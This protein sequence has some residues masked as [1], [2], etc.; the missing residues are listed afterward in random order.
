[1]WMSEIIIEL[2]SCIFFLHLYIYFGARVRRCAYGR[3]KNG[4]QSKCLLLLTSVT[5][6]LENVLI[7]YDPILRLEYVLFLCRCLSLCSPSVSA[8]SCHF[9]SHDF[10]FRLLI[11]WVF[12]RLFGVVIVDRSNMLLIWNLSLLSNW[13]STMTR[14]DLI[15]CDCECHLWI[16]FEKWV[17]DVR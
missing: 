13:L 2:F 9:F 10:P 14:F 12:F 6:E 7:Y 3:K 17:R 16:V 8:F 4:E 1:M 5:F 11:S 15:K